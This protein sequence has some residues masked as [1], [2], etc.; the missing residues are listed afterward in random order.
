MT[1]ECLFLL[2]L[3]VFLIAMLYSSVGHAGA[4]GYIAVMS[5]LSLAPEVIKP[6]A[7]S[8]NILVGSIAT[9]Q[10]YRAGHFSWSLFWP[11]AALAVPCA[12]IGGQLNL[13]THL[14]KMLLGL[15]LLYSALRFFVQSKQTMEIKA[16]PCYQA[17]AAGAGI[18]FL[19]GLTGTGG[20]IFLTPLLLFMG[21]ADAK[22][23]ASVSAL[24]VLLNSISG[25]AGNFSATKAL[26]E[27]IMP[28]LLAAAL[29]GVIGAHFGSRRI[30]PESIKKLLA[31]VLLIAGLK[32]LL[33]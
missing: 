12:F 29:G 3:A 7:L 17:L 6:T 18:G 2:I 21:W 4:S 19:S 13:P 5:L 1:V 26:P 14:F 9:W 11:F 23:A 30:A 24:F 22:R 10:F 27:F 25:L 31:V 15:V 20:G 32:L 8:L 28:L 16:P 33:T